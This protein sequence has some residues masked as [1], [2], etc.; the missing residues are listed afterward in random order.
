[1]LDVRLSCLVLCVL[2]WVVIMGAVG[3]MF[4]IVLYLLGFVKR[5]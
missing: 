2:S 5:R 1:M 4:F 3:S